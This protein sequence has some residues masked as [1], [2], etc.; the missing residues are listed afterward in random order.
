MIIF[1]DGIDGSGKTTLIRHLAAALNRSGT[2]AAAFSPL[3]RYLPTIA[4]PEQF[5]SWVVSTTGM[6]VAEPL[7]GAMIERLDDLRGLSVGQN[8]VHLVDRGPKTVYASA[9]AHAS[10]RRAAL[11]PLRKRLAVSV[12]ALNHV[13]PCMAVELGEGEEALKV[14]LPRLTSSQTVTPRYLRYLRSFATEM[15]TGGDWPGLPTQ[16]LHV[17]GPIELNCAAV[18]ES[19]RLPSA[20]NDDPASPSVTPRLACGSASTTQAGRC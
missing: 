10:E 15:H 3:W 14:A 11:E 8:R 7:I 19:L 12:R 2:E 9:R 1:V 5:A 13:Q 17:S 20:S 6:E 4:A 18:I 16:R